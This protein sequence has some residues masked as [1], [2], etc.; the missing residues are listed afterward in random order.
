ME[1]DFVVPQTVKNYSILG[2]I[3]Q[4][5]FAKVYRATHNPTQTVVALK[6][7]PKN[8][9]DKSLYDREIR[10]LQKIDFPFC[11]KFFRVF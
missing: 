7:S 4:G 1:M 10:L 5:S 8:K 3:G 2:P 11:Y 9:V 6:V